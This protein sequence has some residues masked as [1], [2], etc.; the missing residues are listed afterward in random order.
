MQLVKVEKMPVKRLSEKPVKSQE[1]LHDF[2][3]KMDDALFERLD[4]VCDLFGGTTGVSGLMSAF[5]DEFPVWLE[6]EHFFSHEHDGEYLLINPDLEVKRR[7]VHLYFSK[8]V[9]RRLKMVHQD[10]NYFSMAQIVRKLAEI[11]I[12]LAEKY[13]TGLWDYLRS[14]KWCWKQKCTEWKNTRKPIYRLQLS[15]SSYRVP[16]G[17]ADF[18]HQ[19][20][21]DN[22]F[23]PLVIYLH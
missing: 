8:V 2:H 6:G 3:L 1:C 7:S 4:E 11:L 19:T 5:L 13:G 22:Y 15:S 20:A 10:L 21:Y 17:G 9:F 12:K 16:G 18:G 14:L 23:S